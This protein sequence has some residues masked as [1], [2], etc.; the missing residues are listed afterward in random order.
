MLPRYLLRHGGGGKMKTLKKYLKK[1]KKIF[2]GY[3]IKIIIYKILEKK[4][5]YLQILGKNDII[6]N[7]NCSIYSQT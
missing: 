3:V 1:N 4:L 7:N 5:Y 2:D 6:V